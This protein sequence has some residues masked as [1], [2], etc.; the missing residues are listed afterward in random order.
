MI[1]QFICIFIL[2]FS[3]RTVTSGYSS[4]GIQSNEKSRS[5]MHVLP[6]R[7]ESVAKLVKCISSGG[8]RYEGSN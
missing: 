5:Y 8:S 7:N 1:E 4:I 3:D 6:Y 2:K